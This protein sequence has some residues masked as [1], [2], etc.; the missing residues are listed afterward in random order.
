MTPPPQPLS[1]PEKFMIQSRYVIDA[2]FP[3]FDSAVTEIV[4]SYGIEGGGNAMRIA[5]E[6][7]DGKIYRVLTTV[8]MGAYMH[9]VYALAGLGL[10]DTLANDIAGRDGYDSWFVVTPKTI[11]AFPPQAPK[12]T[13][14]ATD[15]MEAIQAF[16]DMPETERQSLIQSRVGQGIFRDRLIAYWK[17]CAVTG[18]SCVPLLKAS[19]IKPWS[20]STNVERLDHFNGLLLAPNIDAAFDTGYISFDAQG[21]I[22]LSRDIEGQSAFQL[23]ISRKLS[24]NRRLL[25]QRHQQYLEFHRT[26]IFRG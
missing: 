1:P 6:N 10:K 4:S 2:P 8:G 5:I 20:R 16:G 26:E 19:H 21:K 24:I 18:A 17:V 14:A 13:D 15:I 25:D 12:P 23:H 22:L 3:S 9:T 11:E 7:H